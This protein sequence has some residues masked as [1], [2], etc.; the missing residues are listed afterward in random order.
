MPGKGDK[1]DGDTISVKPLV[2]TPVRRNTTDGVS[3]YHA[4]TDD[5]STPASTTK[6]TG[7][8]AQN[9]YISEPSVL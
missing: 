3:P 9:R 5:G 6:R 2:G 7:D 1:R 8:A 4:R